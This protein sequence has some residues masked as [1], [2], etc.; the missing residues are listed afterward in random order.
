MLT[1][2]NIL[3]QKQHKSYLSYKSNTSLM[4]IL[5][6][7]VKIILILGFKHTENQ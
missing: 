7:N 5:V 6:R 3:I 2:L 1:R 4:K